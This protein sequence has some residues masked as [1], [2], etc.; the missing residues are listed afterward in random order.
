MSMH[1]MVDLETLD[2]EP[3]AV[4]LSIGSV[5]FYPGNNEI[6]SKFYAN[7]NPRTQKDR[8]INP[9]TVMWWLDQSKQA[10]DG[11]QKNQSPLGAT[12]QMWLVWLKTWRREDPVIW[13]NSPSFDVDILKHACKQFGLHFPF[14]FRHTRDVRTVKALM[15]HAGIGTKDSSTRFTTHNALEDAAHQAHLVCQLYERLKP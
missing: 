15:E 11:L 9:S 4:I 13:A 10:Q 7:I 6:D 14:D 3:S 2:T 12:L 1:I 5:A 8:T